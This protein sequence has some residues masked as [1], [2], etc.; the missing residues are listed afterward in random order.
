MNKLLLIDGFSILNRAY[1]AMPKL[2]DPSGRPTG[3]LLGF[4]NIIQRVVDEEQPTHIAVALDE[5]APTFRHDIYSDYKGTR[6]S[7][8]DDLRQ[9]VPILKELLEKMKLKAISMIGFEADDIIGSLSKKFADT[10]TY[11][12]VVSGDRDLLQLVDDRIHIR[13]PKTVK[14]QS[15]VEHYDRA[16]V[17]ERYEVEPLGIIELKALMGDS[18]DNI[19]GVKGIGEKTATKL[20]KEYKSIDSLYENIAA[21]IPERI[22]KLLIADKE[23]AFLSKKLATIKCDIKLDISLNSL[24]CY[25]YL[26][27]INC[28]DFFKELNF[29]KQLEKFKISETVM[30]TNEQLKIE[31][32]SAYETIE[33]SLTDKAF[34]T[35][36]GSI[37]LYCIVNNN[38][39]EAVLFGDSQKSFLLD[40][41]GANIDNIE[42]IDFFNRI[43][44]LYATI[45]VFNYKDMLRAISYYELD[46]QRVNDLNLISYIIDSNL[47]DKLSDNGCV[48]AFLLN[49]D[50]P[51]VKECFDGLSLS[52]IMMSYIDRAKYIEMASAYQKLMIK[53]GEKAVLKAKEDDVYELY[54]QIELPLSVVLADMENT[55]IGVDIDILKELSDRYAEN[56]HELQLE[57]FEQAGDVFNINSPKQLGEILFERIGIPTVKKTKLGYSTAAEVLEKLRYDYKIVNDILKYRHFTKLKTTYTDALQNYIGLDNRIHTSF[58]QTVAATGRLS[59]MEPN[60]QNLPTRDKDGK[61]IRAAFLPRAGHIFIDADYSQ[62]ELRV[63]AHLSKD[64]RMLETYRNDGD[65]HSMTAAAVFGVP[66]EKVDDELR[67]NAK[68]VNFGIIYGISAF[69]LGKDINLS[70]KDARHFI[71]SYFKE[72]PSIKAFI[73]SLVSSAYEKGYSTTIFNRK[74]YIPE[75]KSANFNQRSFGARVAMNSPIQGS[76]ADI[77]KIAMIKVYKRLKAESLKTRIVL[78]IHDELLLETPLEEEEIAKK[79]LKDEMENAATL[80]IPL[81]VSL[82]TGKSLLE[83]K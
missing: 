41:A 66:M 26:S 50:I 71:D 69:G 31:L 17:I 54:T 38:D 72:F 73:D 14:G 59:S 5:S 2:S 74:R 19:K 18:S 8:P 24:K 49:E 83:V 30:S 65:I 3:G 57:I 39:I 43:F 7:M 1:F 9:Q 6:G 56:I 75:L 23:M 81:S 12:V 13:L 61:A 33:L 11:V 22:K 42:L 4:V 77:I 76:A 29:K 37:G 60:L 63:L 68:A 27:D 21:V 10:D 36:K 46:H 55:G 40:V 78:Q 80:L 25:D 79:I 16:A 64:E 20:I 28:Y 44:K 35:I 62:I 34:D 67:R 51:G 48:L 15:V 70:P 53:A 47:S 32:D 82:S 52:D 58:N 45:N